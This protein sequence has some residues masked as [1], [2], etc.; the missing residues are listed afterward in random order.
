MGD[1]KKAPDPITKVPDAPEKEASPPAGA[2]TT[3]SASTAQAASPLAGAKPLDLSLTPPSLLG[4]E[5]E[6]PGGGLRMPHLSIEKR[7]GALLGPGLDPIDWAAMRQPFL[8]HNMP[9]TGRDA[10]QITLNF[11]NSVGMLRSWGLPEGTAMKLANIGLAFAYDTQLG[12]ENPNTL[13]KFDRDTERML[14]P[15]K[16]LG[17]FVVPV[18]TP[19]TLGWAVEKVTGKKIDFRF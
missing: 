2:P 13:E 8:T 17:K 14:G 12:L 16:K 9:L 19:D 1:K 11:Y 15:G 5:V 10:D 4:K 6:G 7:A 18:I 3:G